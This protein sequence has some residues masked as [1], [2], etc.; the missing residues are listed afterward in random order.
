MIAVP[1]AATRRR[2]RP[3]PVMREKI[4]PTAMMAEDFKTDCSLISL[5]FLAKDDLVEGRGCVA[6]SHL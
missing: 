5:K 4:V 2:L 3:K 6:N 1:R